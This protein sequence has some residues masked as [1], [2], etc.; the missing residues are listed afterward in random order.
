MGAFKMGLVGRV[1]P[2]QLGPGTVSWHRT[3]SLLLHTVQPRQPSIYLQLLTHVAHLST[4]GY[5][6]G[7]RLVVFV[8]YSKGTEQTWGQQGQQKPAPS[9]RLALLGA[10]RDASQ[11][12]ACVSGP[13]DC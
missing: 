6:A 5:K 11:G 8:P 12:G 10:G 4:S 9:H 1:C 13:R 7:V 3:C 2:A